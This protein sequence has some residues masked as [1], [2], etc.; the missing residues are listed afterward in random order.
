MAAPLL[1]IDS[2]SQ[3]YRGYYAIRALTTAQGIPSNAVFAMTK[4][5]MKLKEEY[6]GYEGALVLGCGDGTD[7]EPRIQDRR[8]FA[9]AFRIEDEAGNRIQGMAGLAF[10][11]T[12]LV[13]F[14]FTLFVVFI[15]VVGIAVVCCNDKDAAGFFHRIVNTLK[16]DVQRSHGDLDRLIDSGMPDHVA[17]GVVETDEVIFA[18]LDRLVDCIMTNPSSIWRNNGRKKS[19]LHRFC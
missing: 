14:D 1:L 2:Y 16:A 9:F 17:V 5:L 6:E 19:W 7:T 15:H 13:V 4:L 10:R 8:I 11:R 12:V 18:A 3:I